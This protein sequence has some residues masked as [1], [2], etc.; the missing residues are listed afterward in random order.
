MF[1]KILL[2]LLGIFLLLFGIA[3]VT[4]IKVVWME[5]IEGL[6]ALAAGLVC[7]FRAVKQ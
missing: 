1:D 4:N 6:A 3:A 5:P 7:V 2:A